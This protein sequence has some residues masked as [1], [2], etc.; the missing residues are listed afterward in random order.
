MDP[1]FASGSARE[2]NKRRM[3]DAG[4]RF[5]MIPFHPLDPSSSLETDD[6]RRHAQ[7]TNGEKKLRET[8]PFFHLLKKNPM[9]SLSLV[10]N[11]SLN[12]I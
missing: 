8:Q 7:Y 11:S 10:L 1:L 2:I 12:V 6:D 3:A 9:T 4:T 5:F